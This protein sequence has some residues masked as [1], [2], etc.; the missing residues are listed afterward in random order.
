MILDTLSPISFFVVCRVL[1]AFLLLVFVGF[2]LGKILKIEMK[3]TLETFGISLVLAINL[4]HLLAYGVFLT[5]SNIVVY[6]VLLGSFFYI[7][8]FLKTTLS[9][10]II[11]TISK[12]ISNNVANAKNIFTWGAC[13]LLVFIIFYNF[14]HRL[15]VLEERENG[16]LSILGYWDDMMILFQLNVTRDFFFP[17]DNP[18]LPGEPPYYYSWLGNAIP[19]FLINYFGIDQVDSLYLWA[20]IFFHISIISLIYLTIKRYSDNKWIPIFSANLFLFSPILTI[21]HFPLRSQGGIFLILSTLFFILR[22]LA[23]EKNV[24]LVLSFSWIFLYAVK[25]NYLLPLFPCFI[26][27]YFKVLFSAGIPRWNDNKIIVMIPCVMVGFFLIWFSRAYFASTFIFKLPDLNLTIF[28]MKLKAQYSSI[29]LLFVIVLFFYVKKIKNKTPIEFIEK[30]ALAALPLIILFSLFA[31]RYLASDTNYLIYLGILVTFPLT[32]QK[33][34]PHKTTYYGLMLATLI[35]FP[36]L[37]LANKDTGDKMEMT[38]DEIQMIGFLRKETPKDTVF[39]S[40]VFRYNDRPGVLSALSYRKQ[41]I[42]EAERFAGILNQKVERRI[43]DYWTFLKCSC[44]KEDQERFITK[45]PFLNYLIIYGNKFHKTGN[46][47]I[48]MRTKGIVSFSMFKPDSELFEP[49]FQ[50]SSITVY[51]IHRNV[52]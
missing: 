45:Y 49:V 17:I 36:S 22:Y 2:A 50:N 19:I 14:H 42:D 48:G 4:L 12:N 16:N 26:I 13:L 43:Y 39:L 32:L 25:P 30:L 40:N 27:F 21:E 24:Y 18:T 9:Q 6:G 35:V 34:I 47:I 37:A 20:P 33:L 31:D 7:L 11:E 44:K 15:G 41:F 28:L 23:T 38:K 51:K 3:G 1:A 5:R 10:P 52:T 29:A 8:Y 46:I